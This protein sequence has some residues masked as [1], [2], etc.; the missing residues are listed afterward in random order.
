MIQKHNLLVIEKDDATRGLLSDLVG[1]RYKQIRVIS[2][3]DLGQAVDVIGK[4]QIDLIMLDYAFIKVAFTEINANLESLKTISNNTPIITLTNKSL[5]EKPEST[6]TFSF[7][8]NLFKPFK[9]ASLYVIIDRFLA[10]QQ[11][12]ATAEEVFIKPDWAN[13]RHIDVHIL[14]Q[15]YSSN[16]EKVVKILKLYPEHINLQLHKINS[17]FRKA[18]VNT[19]LEDFQ[20]L[21]TSFVYF[22]GKEV[23]S[24]IDKTIEFVE[25]GDF[26]SGK[27]S[28]ERL[29]KQWSFMADEIENL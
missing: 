3:K 20:S 12:E 26:V 13:F 5:G 28:L 19:L 7:T 24:T 29:Q 16:K 23:V 8:D 4:E 10:E 22:A 11:I 14:C 17:S 1:V 6:S 21:R 15:S 25:K 9:P 27:E 18:N 2:T